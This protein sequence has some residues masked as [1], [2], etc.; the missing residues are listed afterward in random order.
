M[1]CS[2]ASGGLGGVQNHQRP[3]TIIGEGMRLLW[4]T[5]TKGGLEVKLGSR[6]ACRGLHG[7]TD[8]L[9]QAGR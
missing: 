7:D 4:E 9:L 2:L 8:M 6:G 1:F 5:A 3:V